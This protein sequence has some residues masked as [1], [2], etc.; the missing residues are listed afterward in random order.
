MPT[1]S[2]AVNLVDSVDPLMHYYALVVGRA[3]PDIAPLA[4]SFLH[5]ELATVMASNWIT[6]GETP[7]NGIALGLASRLRHWLI[8]AAPESGVAQQPLAVEIYPEPCDESRAIPPSAITY[9]A[10]AS[11]D[12]YVSE[13]RQDSYQQKL[14][15]V[16]GLLALRPAELA[17]LVGVSREA[18]RQWQA[19]AP[20]AQE[21][22]PDIDVLLATIQKLSA[23]VKPDALPSVIR[24]KAPSLGHQSALEWLSGH[25]YEELLAKYQEAF[26]YE[27]TA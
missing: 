15:R 21:R 20:I 1:W 27:A 5:V 18:L 25:R 4:S 22:W 17:R 12:N 16:Q 26:T 13:S 23:Y 2:A 24:R 19:G 11:L 3:Y 9:I 14:T 7:E 10:S 6:C 8:E